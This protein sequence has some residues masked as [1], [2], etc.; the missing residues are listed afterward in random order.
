ML[1]QGD[2][3]KGGEE[4]DKFLRQLMPSFILDEDEVERAIASRKKKAHPTACDHA[5][6]SF[7]GWQVKISGW[8]VPYLRHTK[9]QTNK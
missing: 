5:Q 4:Y 8:L 9:R 3:D 1:R 6:Q 2:R 7:L